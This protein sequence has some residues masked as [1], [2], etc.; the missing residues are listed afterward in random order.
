MLQ[1]NVLRVI[2]V[3]IYVLFSIAEVCFIINHQE[4]INNN[5]FTKTASFNFKIEKTI[6]KIEKT[7]CLTNLLKIFQI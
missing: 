7:I 4:S 3:L 6:F 1:K 2:S 5:N